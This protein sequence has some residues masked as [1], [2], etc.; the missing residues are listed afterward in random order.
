MPGLRSGVGVIDNED[1]EVESPEEVAHRNR[2]RSQSA[3]L[4]PDR[5]FRMLPRRVAEGKVA[6]LVQRR[7]RF[8]SR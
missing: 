8:V 1:N 4:H 5:R 7:V 6:A 2:A 3:R